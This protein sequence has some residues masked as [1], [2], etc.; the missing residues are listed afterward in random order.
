MFEMPNRRRIYLMRH[1]EAAYVAADG[2]V[3]NDPRNVPLTPT[4]QIQARKQAAV[5][6]LI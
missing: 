6:V 3:T 4:G 2:T 1:G 5:L